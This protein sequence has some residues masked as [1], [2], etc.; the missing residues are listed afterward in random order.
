MQTANIIGSGPNGLAAAITLAQRGVA[1]TVYERNAR[2]GGACSTAEI[3]LPGFHHDLGSSAYPL[4]IASPFFRSLPLEAHG[5][6]WIHSPA[7]LAHPLDDGSAFTL[8]PNLADTIAQFSP[9][10]AQ[11]WHS[12]FASSVRDWPKL[13]EDVTQ[14]LFR[15][16]SHPI[17][18]AFFGLPALLPAQTLA[19]TIFQD[20]PARA[21]FAGCAAH[22]VLPLTHIASS[23]TGL[24]MVASAHTTGWPI[25]AGGAQSIT[26]ALAAYLESPSVGQAG[27]IL[28]NANIADL[29]DLSPA[30]ATLFDTSVPALTRIAGPA[31]TPS[32]VNRLAHFKPGP[33][34]FKLDFA[35]SA[36][37]PWTNPACARAATVHLGGTLPEIVRSEHD[38][39]RLDGRGRLNDNPYILLVQP[40][41]FD[42]SRAPEGKHTAWAYCHVP[43]GSTA[44]HTEIILNQIT[45]FA[46]HFRDTILATVPNNATSLA[47]W[48]PNLAGGD[49]S[50]GAMTLTQLLARP[51]LRQY[52]TS[53]PALYLCSASTPPGGG[54]HGMCGHL[55]ALAALRDHS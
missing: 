42:P 39:C 8:E 3:T 10:D 50:G 43:P 45:R 16:P 14:P 20:A 41:L 26:N 28:L 27:K 2:L 11:A 30:D 46:P 7:A 48:N 6:R 22:S 25:A 23:A 5:L 53:N 37:I 18:M 1:V 17:A 31:L 33:G 55:A 19:K 34:I 9:H 35:L 12:L 4:G 51:T 32:F 40:S 36:P 29:R 47:A 21:L 49:V 24:V 52:R 15:F 54:V 38:A 13:V 44:D